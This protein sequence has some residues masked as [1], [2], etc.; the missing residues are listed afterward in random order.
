[1]FYDFWGNSL[2]E[3]CNAAVKDH[4]N[5]AVINLASNEYINA[6]KQKD[7]SEA[8]LTCHFKELKDGKPKTIG[9][10]AKRAR[11]MM[12][13]FMI[14]NRIE[15]PEALK[16]FDDDGYEFMPSLSD[17]KNFVFLRSSD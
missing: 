13:R 3:A 6:I 7:L 12:A 9:L 10:F 1:M 4:E 16:G 11:G 14:K 17:E 8:L 2:A 5:K 15:D